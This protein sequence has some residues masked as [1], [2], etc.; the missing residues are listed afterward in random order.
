MSRDQQLLSLEKKLQSHLNNLLDHEESLWKMKARI[1]GLP[2]W[3]KIY[4]SFILWL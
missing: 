2:W 1:Q 4:L 3:I